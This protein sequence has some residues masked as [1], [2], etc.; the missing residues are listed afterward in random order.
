MEI[1]IYIGRIIS[2]RPVAFQATAAIINFNYLPI[3]RL[4]HLQKYIKRTFN[5]DLMNGIP[6]I[7]HLRYPHA[8][9]AQEDTYFFVGKSCQVLHI[10]YPRQTGLCE[11]TI[12]RLFL[13]TV[14][15]FLS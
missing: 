10:I 14:T 3:L 9:P 11:I 8:Q 15:G 6:P 12:Y 2:L 1:S 7:F 5:V 13:F 4:L